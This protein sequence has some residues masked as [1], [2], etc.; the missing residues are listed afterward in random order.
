MLIDI[1]SSHVW[2]NIAGHVSPVLI[3]GLSSGPVTPA[4]ASTD[5]QEGDFFAPYLKSIR[6]GESVL[7]R[8]GKRKLRQE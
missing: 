7:L 5:G 8:G 6:M 2:K 1:V 3:P 4:T